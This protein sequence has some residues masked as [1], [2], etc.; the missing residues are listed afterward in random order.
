[1]ETLPEELLERIVSYVTFSRGDGFLPD[2]QTLRA[3]SRTS[4]Q[5]QRIVEPHRYRVVDFYTQ[6]LDEPQ[7]LAIT[8]SSSAYTQHATEV[9]VEIASSA[10]V[11]TIAHRTPR[12]SS[13]GPLRNLLA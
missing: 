8:T 9:L 11:S 3:L 12:T 10:H 2:R 5:L 13:P 4:P 7:Q 6:R 1:M